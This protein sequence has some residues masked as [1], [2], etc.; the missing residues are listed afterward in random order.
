MEYDLKYFFLMVANYPLPDNIE[1]YI[2]AMGNI[3]VKVKPDD[4]VTW[5][6]Y[7]DL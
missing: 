2:K 6:R 4:Y 7:G 1:K 5:L 3:P